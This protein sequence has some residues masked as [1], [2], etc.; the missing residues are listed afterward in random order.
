M[1]A[2]RPKCG[3]HGQS[4]CEHVCGSSTSAVDA[5]AAAASIPASGAVPA[6]AG[7]TSGSIRQKYRTV[8]YAWP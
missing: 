1:L 2:V 5:R 7:T 8:G 4:T 6:H 3:Y